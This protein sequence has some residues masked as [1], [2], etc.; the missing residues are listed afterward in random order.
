MSNIPPGFVATEMQ[1]FV[2]L[3]GGFLRRV[4]ADEVCFGFVAVER[5]CNPFGRIHGGWLATLADLQMILQAARSAEMPVARLVTASL[6]INYLAAAKQGAWV[7]SKARMLRRTRGLIFM[8]GTAASEGR[9]ILQTSGI[10]QIRE[11][12]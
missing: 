5:H 12:R 4:N 7:E 8:E 11:E 3:N 1:G 10:Y 2:G 6:Q 9:D